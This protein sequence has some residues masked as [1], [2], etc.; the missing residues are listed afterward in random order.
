MILELV[1]LKGKDWGEK[2]T[3]RT[4]KTSLVKLFGLYQLKHVY[5]RGN[6]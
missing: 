1:R 3:E 5:H 2:F 6:Q 4:F